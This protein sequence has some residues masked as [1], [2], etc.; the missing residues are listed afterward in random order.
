MELWRKLTQGNSSPSSQSL[1]VPSCLQDKHEAPKVTHSKAL[2]TQAHP[3]CP[4]SAPHPPPIPLLLPH[5]VS[6]TMTLSVH[7]LPPAHCPAPFLRFCPGP[8]ALMPLPVQCFPGTFRRNWG[9]SLVSHGSGILFPFLLLCLCSGRAYLPFCSTR[10]VLQRDRRQCII[11][12]VTTLPLPPPAQSQTW[13]GS[14][15]LVRCLSEWLSVNGWK[16]PSPVP[17]E[18]GM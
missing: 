1:L 16:S 7:T 9:S 11:P 12:L 14:G 2:A 3:D 5:R 17:P 10:K 4:T 13:W 8:P 6:Q 15:N 18:P